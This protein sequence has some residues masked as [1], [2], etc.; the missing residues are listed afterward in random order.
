MGGDREHVQCM[1]EWL[2]GTP[3]GRADADM[4]GPSQLGVGQ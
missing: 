3:E 4:L 2:L 1:P